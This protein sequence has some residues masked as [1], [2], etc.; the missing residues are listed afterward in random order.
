MRSKNIRESL[1]Q[2]YIQKK[3]RVKSNDSNENDQRKARSIEQV[4]IN[5]LI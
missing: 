1:N 2:E 4:Y 5:H 3:K